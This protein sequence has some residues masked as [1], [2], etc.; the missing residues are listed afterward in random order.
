[1]L[2]DMLR[3]GVN[4]TVKPLG[5]DASLIRKFP[6]F[7]QNSR[8]FSFKNP[9]LYG[10]SLIRTTG[11]K[12]RPQRVNSYKLDLFITDTAVIR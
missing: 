6:M 12:S 2:F 8:K 4:G 5:K 1:M 7:R 9:L 10:P 3:G 11:I